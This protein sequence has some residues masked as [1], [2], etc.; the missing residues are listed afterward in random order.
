LAPAR[1]TPSCGTLFAISQFQLQEIHMAEDNLVLY[2]IVFTFG[3]AIAFGAYQWFRAR[4][5][6]RE[7]HHSVQERQQ[8]ADH[9]TR[10]EFS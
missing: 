9:P 5:A 4:K 3:V 7:H 10:K 8:G 1:R 2:L 6:K